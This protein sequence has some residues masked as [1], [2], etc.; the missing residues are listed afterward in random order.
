M[1]RTS[2][3]KRAPRAENGDSTPSRRFRVEPDEAQSSAEQSP[4]E[5][6]ADELR[7]A[8]KEER[9]AALEQ[10]L[11]N[12][13]PG[14]STIFHGGPPQNSSRN[15]AQRSTR[16]SS[17]GEGALSGARRARSTGGRRAARTVESEE[18]HL[19]FEPDEPS[20]RKTHL[21]D[22]S[23][24]TEDALREAA[25]NYLNRYDASVVQLRRVLERRL[26]KYGEPETLPEAKRSI[27]RLLERFQETRLLDDARYARGFAQAARLRGGSNQKIKQKL[28][29]RGVDPELV[30]DSLREL[31]VSEEL[32][33]LTAA[34]AYVKKR[35]LD[36]RHDLKDPKA[37][38]KALASLARQGFSFDVARR[39][40]G[41]G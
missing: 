27:E 16:E 28:R 21:A 25:L 1:Q 41:L 33:E 5:R 37:R 23:K 18:A 6:R 12:Y 34:R 10:L 40:L 32:D 36:T 30:D 11:S 39:A 13:R 35:R 2:I 29:A 15:A 17:Q 7:S 3:S 22:P 38:N 19:H 24:L 8:P 14:E 9:L 26:V 20:P 4:L 31:H